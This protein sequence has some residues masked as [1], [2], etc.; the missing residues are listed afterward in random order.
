M[1]LSLKDYK[2][3]KIYTKDLAVI[4][5]NIESSAKTLIPYLRYKPV[6]HVLKEMKKAQTVLE[7]HQDKYLKLVKNK[8]RVE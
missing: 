8:G 4:I 3:A 6:Q 2:L 7:T 5:K 1:I